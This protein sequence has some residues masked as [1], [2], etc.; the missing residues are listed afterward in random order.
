MV[1]GNYFLHHQPRKSIL[2]S[3]CSQIKIRLKLYFPIY[4]MD[5]EKRSEFSFLKIQNEDIREFLK[6]GKSL[7]WSQKLTIGSN[8]IPEPY[9]T[10]NRKTLW[11]GNH[12]T[13]LY[14]FFLLQTSNSACFRLQGRPFLPEVSFFSR[15]VVLSVGSLPIGAAAR[16]PF[17]Q[18]LLLLYFAG[19]R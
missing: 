4:W 11:R 15:L 5:R 19:R 1:V 14:F 13:S 7:R 9:V 18:S 16:C 17:G 6:L 8:S 10:N 3:F 2:F 12:R